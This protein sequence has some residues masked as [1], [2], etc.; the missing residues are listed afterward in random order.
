[1]ATHDPGP[2]L[3]TV[4]LRLRP[5][6]DADAG[7]FAVVNADPRVAE[8][9]PAPLERPASDALL[10]RIRAH[11]AR[12]GFGLWAAETRAE[13]RLLGFVGLQWVPFE[14]PFTPCVEAGWRLHPD[15]WGQGLATEGARAALRFGFEALGLEQIVAFT[16]PA[17]GASRRVMAKLGMRHDPA[18]DFDHPA[19]PAGHSLRRHVLYRLRRDEPH[20]RAHAGEGP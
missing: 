16:V 12:H 20:G 18:G 10:A 14:A 4:R 19:L 3:E 2:V 13:E 5:W 6:R 8:H 17:N 1:M 7:P 15:C 11:F 9:L